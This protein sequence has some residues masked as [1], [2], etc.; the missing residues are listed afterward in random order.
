MPLLPFARLLGHDQ[1]RVAPVVVTSMFVYIQN[2]APLSSLRYPGWLDIWDVA[3]V[4]GYWIPVDSSLVQV[5][6]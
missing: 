3:L 6:A 1:C 2:I 5:L 4:L